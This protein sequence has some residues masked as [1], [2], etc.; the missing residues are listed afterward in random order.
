MINKIQYLKWLPFDNRD[1]VVIGS[2][3]LIAHNVDIVNNDLD[4]VVRQDVLKEFLLK[5]DAICNET[6]TIDNHIELSYKANGTNKNFNEL[7]INATIIEGYSFMSLFDLRESYIAFG[8]EKDKKKIIII[9]SL[10]N[11]KER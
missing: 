6:Y 11:K 5:R 3:V 10:L 9:N 4:I 2:S 1:I 7:N 8:R